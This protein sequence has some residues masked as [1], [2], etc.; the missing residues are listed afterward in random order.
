MPNRTSIFSV[1]PG[2]AE[3]AEGTIKKVM[4]KGFG[5]ISTANGKD[6]FFHM[7]AVQGASFEDLREG[8][9]VTYTE[10]MGV[11]KG[12]VPKTSN[13]SSAFVNTQCGV[14]TKMPGSNGSQGGEG[15]HCFRGDRSTE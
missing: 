4:D 13:R 9:K 3:M 5:F 14:L 8:Q 15:F 6:L 11:R 7:S 12:R 10:G 2:N 1:I